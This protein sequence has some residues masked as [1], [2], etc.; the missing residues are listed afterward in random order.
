MI[1]NKTR[2]M[3]AAGILESVLLLAGNDTGLA[4]FLKAWSADLPEEDF[5][6]HQ[7][8][9]WLG[10]AHA[11]Q[12]LGQRRLPDQPLLRIY[13]PTPPEHG[14]QSS[15]TVI[16]LVVPNLPFLVDT[17]SM[18][19]A[20]AGYTV[21][22]VLHPVLHVLRDV[23]GE[24]TGLGPDGVA[25]SWMHFEIDRETDPAA[26]TALQGSI[27]EVL[28][29]LASVIAD[30]PRM[31]ARIAACRDDLSANP[32][33]V[34]AA[35]RSETQ[36][37]LSWLLDDHFVILGVRDYQLSADGNAL[38]SEPNSGFGL[39]RNG[40]VSAPSH[41][42]A[43]L[44]P[45]LRALAYNPQTLLILTKSDSR[46]TIHRP[47]YLDVVIVKRV[48]ASG[49]VLGELRL[50]G[51]YTAS[52]YT[53]PPREVPV[54]R[55]KIDAV[56]QQS[57]VDLSGHR[58]KAML[59]VL[60]T[61][62]RDELMETGIEDLTRI[63]SAV[64]GLHERN[65]VRVLFRDDI[66]RRYVS[67]MFYVP[68]DNYTTEVRTRIQQLL[69][70]RMG[71]E[72]CDFNVLL[73][74]S[75]LA[76]IHFIV[77]L[78]H[79]T[80]PVY[81]A[82][83]IEAEITQIA[84][85]WQDE[86]R[87]SL[88]LHSGE[89]LGAA[90]YQRYQR[91]FPPAYTSDF[92]ARVAVYDIDALEELSD[93]SPLTATLTPASH[94]DTRLWR[95]KLFHG[96]DIAISDYIPLLENLAVRVLDERPYILQLDDGPRWIIDIGLQLPV[97]GA[98]EDAGARQRFLDAFRAVFNS[99]SENDSF[100]RLVL[101]AGLAWREVL[102]LRAY[103]RWLKQLNLRNA[104]DTLADCLLAH[105]GIARDLVRLFYLRHDPSALDDVAADALSEQLAT[106]ISALPVAD[107]EKALGAFR[108]AIEATVRTSHFQPA[109]DGLPRGHLSLKIASARVPGMPQPAPLFE[110]FVYSTEVEGVHL[111]GGKVARGGLRWSDRR[112]DF[113]TEV[114]GLVKAQMVKNTVIVPVGSK[115][116]FIVKNPPADREA[117]LARGVECYK[118]FIRGLLD[119]T[120]NLV[121]GK[122]VPPSQTHRRDEDDPYLV[123]AADKGTATFSDVANGL[124]QDYG[125]WLDDAFASGGSVGYDHKKMGITARG[126]WVSVMRH[127]RELGVDVATQPFTA[128]GIGDMSGDV[129]GNGMLRSRVTRLVAAFD[130][131]H[132]FIDPEPDT[133]AS[134]KE[135]ERLYN[136]PRSSWA[137]YDATLISA[138]GGVWPRSAK[139]IPL[140][141]QM[142]ALLQVDVSA[143]EPVALIHLLL[144]APVDL[145]YN[146]G[147]G[148]YVKASSQSQAEANDRGNDILRVDGR[149]LR[150]KVFGEGGNLGM[151]Q[152]GRIEYALAG[153][154]VFTDAI[155]NSAGVDC[156]DHEVNIK[157]L[158]GRIMS[159]GDLT[160]KQRNALLAEM[161][162]DVG[163]LVLRDNELQT[164]ALSLE[165][166][167][168]A[169]LLTVHQ[170]FMQQLET[171]GKLS[172][173]LEYLPT[174]SQC[175]DR[176]QAGS[177]LT[178]PE[179][180]VLLAYAKMVLSEDLLNSELPDEAQWDE[181]LREY[182]PKLLVE[183]FGNRLADHPLRR[184]IVATVL[185]NHAVN[186]QGITFAFRLSEEAER[187]P[188]QV[189]KALAVTESL[190]GSEQ[191]ALAAE[192][193]PAPVSAQT[194]YALLQIV[195][196]QTE[197]ATRWVLQAPEVAEDAAF[198]DAVRGA[199]S[200]L[201]QWLANPERAHARRDE[202]V[203]QG[204]PLE[205]AA[206]VLA[207][208]YAGPLL[209]LGRDDALRSALAER[210]QLYLQLDALLGFDWMTAAIEGLPRDNRWQ[211]LARL[212]ARDDLQ[213][214]HAR[215]VD[216][217]WLG[218]EGPVEAR[219][220]TWQASLE[221]AVLA[222]QRMLEELK[223]STTDLAMI[224]AALRE[225]RHRLMD[226]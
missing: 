14:W 32:P 191:L 132:I 162:D 2:P 99:R 178:G 13:N 124:A 186:R 98:L 203:A 20:R 77:R 146:G 39:L 118:G 129:F 76:R 134:F 15:H 149:D 141:P 38:M 49:K 72:S 158:L 123:V 9:D 120:D 8:E 94:N 125:F 52:A 180:A 45:E 42:F 188:A 28:A 63:V 27:E 61:W 17:V 152:L 60:D 41:A 68:R 133:E 169:S 187:H 47:A 145:I 107:D 10:A 29:T 78:P 130:H 173:R 218:G 87:N 140:S 110:I 69:L 103:A 19:L 82:R 167:Q 93:V 96:K 91:A 105:S 26:L 214:L 46:S 3:H 209:E 79:D 86:L 35:E 176:Q 75:P 157:I 190:L 113:R 213:R 154:R 34:E 196:R 181:L 126:A 108:G 16:E 153:G 217:A 202:W 175:L 177:G 95:I 116:G 104:V 80:C 189:I 21:H 67:V 7:P 92:G 143:L 194:Q 58:G 37:F 142:K 97:A 43:Q 148:T 221:G 164:L 131:R 36:A 155:D 197:R 65:R 117:W 156:S 70:E 83:D 25:E 44:A 31:K 185:T 30:W 59:N 12:R 216:R 121:D 151:T 122:V 23:Q 74:D 182:F 207:V 212:A 51:L 6:T 54:A 144:R 208:E 179:L 4:S 71:G 89:E 220:Q 33:P 150:C 119:L 226:D 225:A 170:R 138:G 201:A 64:V 198:A 223:T 106:T 101:H 50:L 160:L 114:L 204:V 147:I 206:R 127:F 171:R 166:E 172:R 184:E 24:L 192:A 57:G 193:L 200:G 183:R 115:G 11:H 48:D 195:R 73:S 66:Y 137:D 165:A 205:L 128:I 112:D 219:L 159:A 161:T 56:L 168:A 81:S 1:Q 211:A 22:L 102:V 55:R 84:Q 85:R 199:L 5:S 224:S 215:L 109:P 139:S 210:L 163:H 111:R 135:R 88:L 174:D 18:A 62:P 100:N 222:W 90:R 136:L 53:Q 40:N